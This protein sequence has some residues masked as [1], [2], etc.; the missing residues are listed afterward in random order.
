MEG[1]ADLAR[2]V[3]P[4]GHQVAVKVHRKNGTRDVSD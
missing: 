3:G 2:R 1:E 4:P